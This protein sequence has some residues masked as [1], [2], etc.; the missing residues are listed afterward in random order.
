MLSILNKNLKKPLLH[1]E[2]LTF[3]GGVFL[4]FWPIS[5]KIDGINRW[6]GPKNQNVVV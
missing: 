4:D 2:I 6:M 3:K 5:V 1:F